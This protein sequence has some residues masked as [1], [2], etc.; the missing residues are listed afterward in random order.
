MASERTLVKNF[1]RA[2]MTTAYVAGYTAVAGPAGTAAALA[3]LATPLGIATIELVSEQATDAA[4]DSKKMAAGGIITQPT[5]AMLGEAGPEMVIPLTKKPRSRKQKAQ[6]K[7]KSTAW[8]LAN[9]KGR[10]KNGEYYAGWDQRRIAEYANK[11]L[12]NL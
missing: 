3:S 6:D 12:K 4:I 2:L 7:K 5:F 8:A 9:A 11:V 10:K 1:Y